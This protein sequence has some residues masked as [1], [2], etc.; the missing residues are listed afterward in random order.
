MNIVIYPDETKEYTLKFTKFFDDESKTKGLLFNAVRI[1]P[2][3]SGFAELKEY[4][5]SKA[6]KV[7][8]WG[9]IGLDY[10]RDHSPREVQKKA[11]CA[12][13]EAAKSAGLPIIIHDR[14]AHQD[15]L[16][17]LKEQH[18]GVNG[19]ILH[20]FSGSWEMAKQCMNMG[21][22]ISFAASVNSFK[23]A[24]SAKNK[25]SSFPI[26][27]PLSTFFFNSSTL[28]IKFPLTK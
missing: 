14:D 15:T 1:L 12:Q 3:Y 27:S 10:Y 2:K 9:E 8:A 25:A 13:I 23:G 7:V 5:L 26:S 21:F 18:G 24:S 22:L 4:E 6:E 17:I 19:G 16:N 11:F 28:Y 20:C